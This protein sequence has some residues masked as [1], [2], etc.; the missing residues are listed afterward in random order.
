MYFYTNIA[1]RKRSSHKKNKI[2][3]QDSMAEPDKYL[4]FYVSELHLVFLGFA[5][6]LQTRASA[7]PKYSELGELLYAL[8]QRP[9]AFTTTDPKVLGTGQVHDPMRQ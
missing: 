2:D 1:K 9:D 8:R 5:P 4:N 7:N 3:T 6:L